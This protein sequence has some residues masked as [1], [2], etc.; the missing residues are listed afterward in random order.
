M[1]EF[2]T[3]NTQPIYEMT[4]IMPCLITVPARS[5]VKD[6]TRQTYNKISEKNFTAKT[7]YLSLKA[8]SNKI[9]FILTIQPMDNFLK[10]TR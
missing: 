5:D 6:S 9:Y 10:E 7:E 4:Y 3:I 8:P 2:K 1:F